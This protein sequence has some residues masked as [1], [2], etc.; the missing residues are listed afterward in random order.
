MKDESIIDRKSFIK[1]L[2][3]TPLIVEKLAEELGEDSEI[4]KKI[5]AKLKK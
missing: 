4:M 5:R 1:S 2:A 3:I